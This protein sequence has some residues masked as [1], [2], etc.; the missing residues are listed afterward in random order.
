MLECNEIEIGDLSSM[1]TNMYSITRLPNYL[2]STPMKVIRKM[3]CG[4]P[5]V[6]TGRKVIV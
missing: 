1:M 5:Q 6:L 2:S 3:V 4:G